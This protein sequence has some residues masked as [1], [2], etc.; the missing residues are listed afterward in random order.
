MDKGW[1]NVGHYNINTS[2]QS[3]IVPKSMYKKHQ[4]TLR[5]WQ[6]L[7]LKKKFRLIKDKHPKAAPDILHLRR[8]Q[9]S[10][11]LVSS[12]LSP[13]SPQ[14]TLMES[15]SLLSFPPPPHIQALIQIHLHTVYSYTTPSTFPQ[16]MDKQSPNGQLSKSMLSVTL[17]CWLWANAKWWWKTQWL[18][19]VGSILCFWV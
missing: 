2:L 7:K 13:A 15:F 14:Q 3:T 17:W 9:S 1:P 8:G 12:L 19:Y 4:L 11:A 6:R 16:L 18:V 5:Q 10:S